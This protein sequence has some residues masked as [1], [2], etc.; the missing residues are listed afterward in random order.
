MIEG[1]L[2]LVVDGVEHTLRPGDAYQIP[3]GIEHSAR[4]EFGP[5]RVLDVFQP[6]REDYRQRAQ[7]A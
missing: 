5:C 7:Q 4:A 2:I 1:E 3:G 6:V